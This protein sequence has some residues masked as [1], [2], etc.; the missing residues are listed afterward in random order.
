M[1]RTGFIITICIL[2]LFVFSQPVNIEYARKQ[3][4]TMSAENCN[5]LHMMDKFEKNPP[6]ES[7]L[8]AYFGAASASAPE[9]V[10]NPASKL[11]MFKKGKKLI[12]QAVKEDPSNYEIRFL[13]FAT[14]DK[15]PG[16]LGYNN[17][18]DDDKLFLIS[19][20]KKAGALYGNAF[21]FKEML[22]FM[23]NSES[24]NQKEKKIVKDYLTNTTN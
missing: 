4:F 3:Y 10:V 18:L 21:F 8:K 11:S 12:D 1:M 13:R 16:F 5:S 17:N 15:A 6:K 14:Q 2:P 22:N 20:I 19:N 23:L 24:V 9:C 7:V